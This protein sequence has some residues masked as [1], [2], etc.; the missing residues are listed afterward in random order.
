MPLTVAFDHGGR[1]DI[2]AAARSLIR[3]GVPAEAVAER[4]KGG[5]SPVFRWVVERTIAS[6]HG[7][8]RLRIPARHPAHRRFGLGRT[9]AP[10]QPAG[11]APDRGV[12]VAEAVGGVVEMVGAQV[13]D[14]AALASDA[15]VPAEVV[16]QETPGRPGAETVPRMGGR[17]GP[18]RQNCAPGRPA[19]AGRPK[20]SSWSVACDADSASSAGL[21]VGEVHKEIAVRVVGRRPAILI[22][23]D[24][25]RQRADQRRRRTGDAD[26]DA[27]D[28]WAVGALDVQA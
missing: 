26:V 18:R 21:P 2:V 11:R 13:A 15:D 7:F 25:A 20:Q 6:L 4:P 1:G 9:A 19:G 17:R 3:G 24:E 10:E 22:F 14:G 27:D 16:V 28:A 5:P 8:R 12:V 23:F